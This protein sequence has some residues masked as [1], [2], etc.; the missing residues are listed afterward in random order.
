M[1]QNPAEK[2]AADDEIKDFLPDPPRNRLHIV[3]ER[4]A[5]GMSEWSSP[6]H[7]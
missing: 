7:F 4:P 6:L 5:T 3:V 1:L 2:L